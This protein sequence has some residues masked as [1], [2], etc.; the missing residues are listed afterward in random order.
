MLPKSADVLI[1][2]GG[3]VGCATAFYLAKAGVRA[4]LLDRGQLAG[5][6]SGES[7]GVLS[8]PGEN[9]PNGGICRL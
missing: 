4:L 5:E 6:A 1:V 8:P 9:D 7:A 3:I 2:G